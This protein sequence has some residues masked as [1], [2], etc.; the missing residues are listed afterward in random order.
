MWWLVTNIYTSYGSKTPS[1]LAQFPQ[2]IKNNKIDISLEN[3]TGGKI[4][5]EPFHQSFVHLHQQK[6]CCFSYKKKLRVYT[7]KDSLLTIQK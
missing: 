5:Q 6:N 4:Q 7:I 1:I 3:V 2:S